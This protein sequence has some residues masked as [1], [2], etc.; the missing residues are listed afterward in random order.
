M[1]RQKILL[2]MTE[3]SYLSKGITYGSLLLVVIL[4]ALLIHNRKRA[5][6]LN[7]TQPPEPAP[8]A[9]PETVQPAAAEK[10]SV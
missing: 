9:T 1:D 8:E 10:E 5:Q 4:I 6:K 7:E 3:H 2:W